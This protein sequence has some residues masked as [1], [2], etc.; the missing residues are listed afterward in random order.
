MGFVID[1]LKSGLKKLYY[2]FCCHFYM[3]IERNPLDI[4]LLSYLSVYFEPA[5]ELRCLRHKI[6]IGLFL[7]VAL[8]DIT[9]CTTISLQVYHHHGISLY[10]Y[11]AISL[12]DYHTISLYIKF[13]P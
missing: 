10:H 5:R 13:K 3:K 6:H 7:A 8:T 2:L 11:Q 12:Y 9:W 4:S 1:K